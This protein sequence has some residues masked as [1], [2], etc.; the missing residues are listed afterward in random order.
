M[1]FFSCI[2]YQILSLVGSVSD[3]RWKQAILFII[4]MT[5]VMKIHNNILLIV[6]IL[7]SVFQLMWFSSKSSSTLESVSW[8]L[9]LH[10]VMLMV[11]ARECLAMI[12]SI[13]FTRSFA[14]TC[15][16]L[17]SITPSFTSESHAFCGTCFPF[18]VSLKTSDTRNLP[19]RIVMYIR[20]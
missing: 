9:D 7:G 6:N 16:S 3:V 12:L 8:I 11:Q 1:P 4:Q 2:G 5:Q 10:L 13:S 14:V 18:N 15:W 17:I 19:N 20:C